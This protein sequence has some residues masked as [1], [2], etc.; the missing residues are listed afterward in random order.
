MLLNLETIHYWLS[1]QF[2]IDKEENSLRRTKSDISTF[3]GIYFNHAP[4]VFKRYLHHIVLFCVQFLKN[5][6]IYH[7]DRT[8]K[9]LG[10]TFTTTS[11]THTCHCGNRQK[12]LSCFPMRSTCPRTVFRM[13]CEENCENLGKNSLL[14]HFTCWFLISD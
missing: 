3:L 1:K 9:S 5:L 4:G 10:N 14:S 2:L 12:T 6:I 13:C 11:E 7:L 8:H